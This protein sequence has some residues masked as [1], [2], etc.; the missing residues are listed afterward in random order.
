[1][2]HSNSAYYHRKFLIDS[3]SFDYFTYESYLTL[4]K[5]EYSYGHYQWSAKLFKVKNRFTCFV[6][7]SNRNEEIAIAIPF[8]INASN[9]VEINSIICPLRRTR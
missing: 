9:K 6:Y 1:M 3:Y 2:R 4:V 8:K 5:S 7:S